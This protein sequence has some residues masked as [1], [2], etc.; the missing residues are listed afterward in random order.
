[1]YALIEGERVGKI[2]DWH[3]T[4]GSRLLENPGLIKTVE[5]NRMQVLILLLS[6]GDGIGVG[7]GSGTITIGKK[8]GANGGIG[9]IR[10]ARF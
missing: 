4:K 5:M 3:R 9:R 6:L 10:N 8:I 7:V 2:G 1:M